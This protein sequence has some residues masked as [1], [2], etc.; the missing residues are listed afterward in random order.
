MEALLHKTSDQSSLA[1]FLIQTYVRNMGEGLD[2]LFKVHD[3]LSAVLFKDDI[4]LS[5]RYLLKTFS[6][7]FYG[8]GGFI[9]KFEEHRRLD[10][11]LVQR[12]SALA[13]MIEEST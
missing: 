8:R 9:Y 7:V 4:D 13:V 1:A 2:K 11:R 6:S 3:C 10:A 5:V 12:I